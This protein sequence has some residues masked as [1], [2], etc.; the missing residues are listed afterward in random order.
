MRGPSRR[1]IRVMLVMVLIG[2][3][4]M[5]GLGVAN[6]SPV[7]DVIAAAGEVVYAVD[8]AG[9]HGKVPST[10]QAGPEGQVIQF[11][12][13][14]A[15]PANMTESIQ[16]GVDQLL[17]QLRPNSNGICDV[18]GYS[19]GG[20]VVAQTVMEVSEETCPSGIK[21]TFVGTPFG[22][23]SIAAA[24]PDNPLIK[25]VRGDLPNNV[26]DPTFIALRNDG[27]PSFG[28]P[29]TSLAGIF[30]GHYCSFGVEHCYAGFQGPWTTYERNGV[31]Y[32][33]GETRNPV[34]VAAESLL[35]S[36][37]PNAKLDPVMEGLID[38]LLPQGNPGF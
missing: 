16:D 6:A 10:P 33:I 36:N 31:T 19:L 12:D 22:P 13:Y 14:L 24:L 4:A 32:V 8:G 9:S 18:M 29:I 2:A 17:S 35:Q 7:D 37:D 25:F 27:Y 28:N 23:G 1:K 15:D 11:V 30:A 21:P 3:L 5:C 38:G 20:L 34:A 26:V